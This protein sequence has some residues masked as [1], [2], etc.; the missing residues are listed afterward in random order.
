MAM[1]NDLGICPREPCE[2]LDTSFM[3]PKDF[4]N[5]LPVDV[6]P[7]TYG[8]SASAG[9]TNSLV[10]ASSDSP[11]TGEPATTMGAA[12]TPITVATYAA[13][14]SSAPKADSS[15]EADTLTS[16]KVTIRVATVGT[17]GDDGPVVTSD[18]RLCPDDYT[19]GWS[20][21]CTV[22]GYTPKYVNFLINGAKLRNEYSSPFSVS[23]EKDGMVAE[24]T[25]AR[26]KPVG[27]FEIV[28]ET[29]HDDMAS[30]K[31]SI[32]CN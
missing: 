21:V 18:Y 2:G 27:A 11:S 20:L 6:T 1:N 9:A 14:M 7:E 17:T 24:W 15:T 8:G 19:E 22:D 25:A 23:A 31:I 13:D 28:C 32:G 10:S 26:G 3:K 16:S 5:G 29:D 4:V 30:A 12:T